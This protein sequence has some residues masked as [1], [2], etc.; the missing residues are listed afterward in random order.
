MGILAKVAASKF[1]AFPIVDGDGKLVG[2][3]SASDF[4]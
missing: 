3:F 2:N 4:T 1:A